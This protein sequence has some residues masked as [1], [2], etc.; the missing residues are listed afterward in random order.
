MQLEKYVEKINLEAASINQEESNKNLKGPKTPRNKLI[1]IKNVF[2]SNDDNP[3]S[4]HKCD[5]RLKSK[6]IHSHLFLSPPKSKKEVFTKLKRIKKEEKQ[7]TVTYYVKHEG[8][9]QQQSIFF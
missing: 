4:P 6:T 7:K 3:V 8:N 2:K 1:K 9:E 5:Q